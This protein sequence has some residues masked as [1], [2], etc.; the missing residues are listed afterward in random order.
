MEGHHDE[1]SN[2]GFSID[3][4]SVGKKLF[5]FLNRIVSQGSEDGV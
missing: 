4:W 3:C 1:E 2:I 5:T